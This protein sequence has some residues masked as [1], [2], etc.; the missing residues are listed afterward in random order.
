VLSDIPTHRELWEGAA[1]FVDPSEPAAVAE[2][3]DGLL[4]DPAEAARLGV[5]A[6]R[7]AQTFTVAAMAE[8][9]LRV[10]RELGAFA[11]PAQEAAA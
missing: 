9:V 10:Y 1:V 3:F 4:A 6:E 5:L 7:R 2:M 8:G 11:P